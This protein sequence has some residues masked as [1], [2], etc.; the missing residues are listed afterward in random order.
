[1]PGDSRGY[2]QVQAQLRLLSVKG[3]AMVT[4]ALSQEA[5]HQSQACFRE[6]R[7]P[8]GTPWAALKH[9]S[10][11]PL[12]LTGRGR[13]SLSVLDL[14]GVRF[15]IGTNVWYMALHQQGVDKT[16]TRKASSRIQPVNRA[17][18]FVTKK[19]A[20]KAKLFQIYYRRLDFHGGQVHLRIPQRAFL[21][22]AGRGV[23]P[24]W[25]AAF[26]KA[27]DLV[28]ARILERSAKAVAAARSA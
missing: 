25:D 23:G 13:A 11:K 16:Y 12:L 5:L 3:M 27:A 14:G 24:I 7:D 2:A 20:S 21:P 15:R 19:R 9:R 4:K 17:G 10:G 22:I 6:S 18:K 26:R 1:V 8:Y 28:L